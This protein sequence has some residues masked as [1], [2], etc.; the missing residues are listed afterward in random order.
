[1]D[2]KLLDYE[3]VLESYPLHADCRKR[4]QPDLEAA[5]PDP[6][7]LAEQIPV[8]LHGLDHAAGGPVVVSAEAGAGR[9]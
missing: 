4:G 6:R 9:R 8:P 1:M 7:G 2:R 5:P 3:A